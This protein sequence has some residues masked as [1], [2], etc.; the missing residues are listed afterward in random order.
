MS[1]IAQRMKR[2]RNTSGLPD[3]LV[4]QVCAWIAADLGIDG[5]DVECRR[6]PKCALAGTSYSQGCSLHTT[7][8]PFVVLRVGDTKLICRGSVHSTAFCAAAKRKGDSVQEVSRFPCT[9]EPYQ[10]AQHKGRRVVI[11]SRNEALVYIAAHELRHLWQAARHDDS[12]K[13]K[14]LPLYHGAHGKFSEVDTESYALHM[15][16]GWRKQTN[17]ATRREIGE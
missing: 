6:T 2:L 15:L 11:S 8:R 5:F 14:L 3:N 7:A 13:A 10:L 17:L 16:R 1:T 9:I 4:R 12:R